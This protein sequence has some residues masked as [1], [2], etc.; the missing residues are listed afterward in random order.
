MPIALVF[1]YDGGQLLYQSGAVITDESDDKRSLHSFDST[2][3][4]TA[5]ILTR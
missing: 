2:F 3:S 5:R 1:L 4:G